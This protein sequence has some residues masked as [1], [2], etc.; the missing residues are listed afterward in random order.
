MPYPSLSSKRGTKY[1]MPKKV[2]RRRNKRDALMYYYSF[3]KFFSRRVN[4][5]MAMENENLQQDVKEIRG[6]MMLSCWDDHGPV[7]LRKAMKMYNRRAYGL[8]CDCLCC[9]VEEEGHN[10]AILPSSRTSCVLFQM[11]AIKMMK[12]DIS[13]VIA[14]PFEGSE[15][16]DFDPE[17]ACKYLTP[18]SHHDVHLVFP[19]PYENPYKFYYGRQLWEIEDSFDHCELNKLKSLIEDLNS[20]DLYPPYPDPI[21]PTSDYEDAESPDSPAY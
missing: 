12:H 13:F 20:K 18:V 3:R 9:V 2:I 21:T 11:L 15:D 7:K 10:E 17:Y 4:E 5:E 16:G 14:D 8:A 19:E 1:Y 6:R